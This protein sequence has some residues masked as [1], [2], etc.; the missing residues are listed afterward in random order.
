MCL[1]V[2]D[3]VIGVYTEIYY[4]KEYM[5]KLK[6]NVAEVN[7]VTAVT[8]LGIPIQIAYNCI[9]FSTFHHFN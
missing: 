2:T 5:G 9:N 8:M 3:A 4:A 1:L 7:F 6:K